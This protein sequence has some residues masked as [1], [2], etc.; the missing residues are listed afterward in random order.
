MHELLHVVGLCSDAPAHFNIISAFVQDP[1]VVK[2]TS[3]VI[4]HVCK[5]A[6]CKIK[7]LTR[8]NLLYGFSG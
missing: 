3:L 5:G 2:N 1:E 7:K 6:L 8:S 4:R